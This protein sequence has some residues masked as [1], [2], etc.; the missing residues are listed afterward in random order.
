MGIVCGELEKSD[1]LALLTKFHAGGATDVTKRQ[2]ALNAVDESSVLIEPREGDVVV[3]T[4]AIYMRPDV[5]VGNWRLKRAGVKI[6]AYIHDFIP[7][8]HPEYVTPEGTL[9]FSTSMRDSMLTID[10]ALTVSKHVAEETKRLRRLSGF[11]EI[12]VK[13]VLNAHEMAVD[14]SALIEWTPRLS[15]L[16]DKKFI[17]CVATMYPHKN[18]FFL[19]QVWRLLIDSG[20]QPPILVCAGKREAHGN[21]FTRQLSAAPH[22]AEYIRFVDAPSDQELHALYKACAFTILPSLVEG[23]GLPVGESLFLG[24]LCVASNVASLPEV[25]GD[26]AIYIDPY[27]PRACAEIIRELLANDGEELRRWEARIAAEFR[28]R[29]WERQAAEFLGAVDELSRGAMTD[30]LP[31]T[32]FA[33]EPGKTLKPRHIPPRSWPHER[34]FGPY[35]EAFQSMVSRLLLG[36]GWMT[37]ESWGTWMSGRRASGA[38]VSKAA[39]GSRV[40]LALLLRTAPWTMKNS[41]S[42]IVQGTR[43]SIDRLTDWPTVAYKE[44]LISTECIVGADGWIEFSLEIE[45]P[46]E[47]PWWGESHPTHVGLIMV[48]HYHKEQVFAPLDGAIMRFGQTSQRGGAA[49]VLRHG[50]ALLGALREFSV[51]AEGWRRQLGS[52][53][54]KRADAARL[55]LPLTAPAGADIRVM[56]QFAAKAPKRPPSLRYAFDQ[57]PYREKKLS[58]LNV[59]AD[60][61]APSSGMLDIDITTEQLANENV[62]LHSVGLAPLDDRLGCAALM[63]SLL[64]DAAFDPRR[65]PRKEIVDWL[66]FT[67]AGHFAGSYSLAAVNR[68]LALALECE[69]PGKVRAVQIEEHPMRD[70]L[71]VP[72]TEVAPLRKLFAKQMHAE[73]LE[74]VICQHWP[75]LDNPT[76]GDCLIALFAWEEGVVPRHIVETF[77]NH[78]A[79]VLALSASVMKSL[80]DSGLILPIRVVGCC[81]DLS[82]LSVIGARAAAG[83]RARHSQENPFTFLHVSSCLPRKGADVLIKAFVSAFK[84]SDPVR[85]IIKSH[86]NPHNDV[87]AMLS[88]LSLAEPSAPSI[89]LINAVYGDEEMTALYAQ[90]DALVLPSRGEGFTLPA[91]EAMAAG[92]PVIITGHGGHMDFVDRENSRI[93]DYDFAYSRT[94]VGA[95][96]SVWVEPKLCDLIEALKEAVD[97]GRARNGSAADNRIDRARK[98]AAKLGD[99][100]RWAQL[101]ID[102][103][104]D[105]VTQPKRP[106]PHIAWVTTWRVPCGLA[107]YS[108]MMLDAYPN[109]KNLIEIFCDERTAPDATSDYRFRRAWRVYDARSL[110]TLV[111]EISESSA[112]VIVIQH[113]KGLIK[114][115]DLTLLLSNPRIGGRPVIIMLHNVQELRDV[116]AAERDA[117]LAALRKQGR[118]LVHSVHD[119]N[120]LKCYGLTDNVALFPHGAHQALGAHRDE[121]RN[122][123]DAPLIGSYGFFLPHK[124][125]SQLITAFASIRARWPMA[126][127]RLVNARHPAQE[128]ADEIAKCRSLAAQ[129]G[130]EH[131][132]EWISDYLANDDSLKLLG[133]CDLLTMPYQETLELASGAL[134]IALAS[135]AP[136][137]VTPL[138]IFDD[139]REAVERAGGIESAD[140]AA[141][142]TKLLESR[143]RR[144][145]I[146]EAAREWLAHH[147]WRLLATRLRG[148]AGG[149]MQQR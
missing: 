87:A 114:W 135:L 120:A 112:D 7:L 61:K 88:K 121:P 26:L 3:T 146:R 83:G 106:D 123:G 9:E 98:T 74:A 2:A 95:E 142:I 6:G 60:V 147:D 66:C 141:G 73:G 49:Y 145:Q 65:P 57:G 131:A 111:N 100:S 84:K 54:V 44:S 70:L 23:W 37:P 105:I 25:G 56:M 27:N 81:P 47:K 43:H 33:L 71:D 51:L 55:R 108:K 45:G 110:D 28:P 125:I 21:D 102:A 4:G 22:L 17:L 50:Q 138:P 30:P 62:A 72:K 40:V 144:V 75:V 11:P 140:L 34:F 130:V 117:V 53:P 29:S 16:A 18:H 103:V 59:M 89:D 5:A 8:T 133:E 109:A 82:Q 136:V 148:L 76:P 10:F 101:I 137:L 122:F 129:L 91:V 13:E 20:H 58:L 86:P 126:R 97:E 32:G 48:A 67:I 85:L 78:Y 93:L 19:L 79:G 92:V 14:K 36:E 149:L 80:I 107:E 115:A 118:V 127:L 113:H 132:I 42:L 31:S 124:G 39:S 38:F 41:V 46:L 64:D 128:S 24:K 15:F 94:H 96:G 35:D 143:K 12:P 90:A 52:E 119:L 139:A 69:K 1:L 99:R 116:E 77:N 104:A 134:R 68:S 63:E